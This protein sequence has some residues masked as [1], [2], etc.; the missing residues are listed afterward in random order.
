MNSI[1]KILHRILC[2]WYIMK[3]EH[4]MKHCRMS[5]TEHKHMGIVYVFARPYIVYYHYKSDVFKYCCPQL[6]YCMFKISLNI[7]LVYQCIK[8]SYLYTILTSYIIWSGFKNTAFYSRH[9]VPVNATNK[10]FENVE[11]L[12]MDRFLNWILII[13]AKYV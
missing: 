4:K 7:F 11:F 5:P 9:V 8:M 12:W 10:C 13:I 3:Y 2:D 6:R 1:L